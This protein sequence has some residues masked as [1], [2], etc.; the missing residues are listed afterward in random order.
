[1]KP[2]EQDPDTGAIAHPDEITIVTYLGRANIRLCGKLEADE[3]DGRSIFTPENTEQIAHRIWD[4]RLSK[5][6]P[7]NMFSAYK[8]IRS[9]DT[10][11]IWSKRPFDLGKDFADKQIKGLN[12]RAKNELLEAI[13]NA[14]SRNRSKEEN[15]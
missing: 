13:E 7:G 5:F 8:V 6:T 11:A 4:G 1:M 3:T 9:L 15:Q 10:I 14:T 2:M 12:V